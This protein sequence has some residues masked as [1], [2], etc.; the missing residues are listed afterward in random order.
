MPLKMPLKMSKM[1]LKMSKNSI[2]L[3]QNFWYK[4]FRT[5]I[6]GS[7][8]EIM[9]L[10]TFSSPVATN[11]QE[12]ATRCNHPG[13]SQSIPR[14]P[15]KNHHHHHIFLSVSSSSWS[16]IILNLIV[17]KIL[18]SY[19]S[20]SISLNGHWAGCLLYFYEKWTNKP[21]PSNFKIIFCGRFLLWALARLIAQLYSGDGP[22]MLIFLTFSVLREIK[23]WL[24]SFTLIPKNGIVQ[25][26]IHTG[27]LCRIQARI[28]PKNIP[29][30]S[31]SCG[32][33][34]KIC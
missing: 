12:E 26:D 14:Q 20:M 7:L 6:W 25:D 21:M 13:Q 10:A 33:P 3:S 27:G 16:I 19:S 11:L 9:P 23:K 31:Y 1:L 18:K 17:F 8:L 29:S 4:K 5:A 22:T 2:F 24:F 28:A 15:W 32:T 30:P 34:W